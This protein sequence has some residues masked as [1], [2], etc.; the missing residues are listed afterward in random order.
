MFR[1]RTKT[2][3]LYV[4]PG[5]EK[6]RLAEWQ[7]DRKAKAGR[8][9]ETE[10][11]S[12]RKCGM[13]LTDNRHEGNIYTRDYTI[14]IIYTLPPSCSRSKMNPRLF[15]EW[16]VIYPLWNHCLNQWL[17]T[18]K[19]TLWN[20]M[21]LQIRYFLSGQSPWCNWRQF[22]AHRPPARWVNSDIMAAAFIT[23]KY[24]TILNITM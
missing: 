8:Y 23:V 10:R 15:S 3:G 6:N 22:L 20:D 14:S 17:P 16:P 13:K 24:D 2:H 5:R 19:K 12:V 11:V 18:I 7:T 4:G 21:I 9:M 1:P